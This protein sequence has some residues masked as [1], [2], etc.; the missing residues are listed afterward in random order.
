MHTATFMSPLGYDQR[1]A[2]MRGKGRGSESVGNQHLHL[3]CF[4]M[5]CIRQHIHI[6]LTAL[7]FQVHSHTTNGLKRQSTQHYV[8]IYV[9]PLALWLH[10]HSALWGQ[11][12]ADGTCLDFGFS[13]VITIIIGLII[14]VVLIGTVRNF[15]LGDQENCIDNI[16]NS[17]TISNNLIY[18]HQIVRLI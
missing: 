16:Y 9:A 3:P 17:L 15:P 8:I 2:K 6:P 18:F 13:Y 12:Y 11:I 14:V 10:G 5:L 1:R 7:H 4:K